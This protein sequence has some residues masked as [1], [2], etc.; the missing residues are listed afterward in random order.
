MLDSMFCNTFWLSTSAQLGAVGTNQLWAAALAN[1][2]SPSKLISDVVFGITLASLTRAVMPV[3]PV[4]SLIHSSAH[5]TFLLAA[6]I[7]RSEPPR[8]VG[9]GALASL[10][11]IGKASIFSAGL[12]VF[13]SL[14][15]PSSQ[16]LPY[17]IAAWPCAIAESCFDSSISAGALLRSL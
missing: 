16:P 3:V 1:G 5:A 13:G 15:D 6:G 4:K 9:S 10:P 17:I 7:T 2:L 12:P 11:G 14:T 8:N